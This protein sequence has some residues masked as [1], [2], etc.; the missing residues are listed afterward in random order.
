LDVTESWSKTV[1]TRLRWWVKPGSKWWDIARNNNRST[2][3][4]SQ[5]GGYLLQR[6][7]ERGRERQREAERGRERQRGREYWADEGQSFE[8]KM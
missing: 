8:L 5:T 6:E 7:A 4:Q 2:N 3:R 1:S